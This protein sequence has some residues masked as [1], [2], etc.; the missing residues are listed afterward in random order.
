MA[1][2]GLNKLI[3]GILLHKTYLISIGS[4]TLLYGFAYVP[5]PRCIHVGMTD[6]NCF[7]SVVAVL[8][9][10]CFLDYRLY[11]TK[12]LNNLFEGNIIR[13]CGNLFINIKKSVDSL[14]SAEI[15]FGNIF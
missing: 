4:C 7:G 6:N 2:R 8:C 13:S 11:C 1:G 5:Q 3:F 14:C 12:S 9:G 15:V 10:K